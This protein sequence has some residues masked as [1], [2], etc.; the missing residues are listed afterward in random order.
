MGTAKAGARE[1]VIQL[2][3]SL[4]FTGHALG[5]VCMDMNVHWLLKSVQQC[6]HWLVKV[7]WQGRVTKV[8]VFTEKHKGNQEC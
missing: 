7:G 2:V 8:P 3:Y 4:S 5:S 1:T 6:V